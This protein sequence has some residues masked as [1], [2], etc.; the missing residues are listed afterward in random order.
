[1]LEQTVSEP[2]GDDKRNK[3]FQEMLSGLLQVSA[4]KVGE[5]ITNEMGEKIVQLLVQIFQSHKCVTESGL[6]AYSGLCHG[7]QERVNVKD[8]G[9]YLVWALTGDDDECARVA[10][11]IV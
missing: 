7:M 10:C 3:N 6:L 8:F 2:L 9:D 5:I 1:M 11:G 4:P